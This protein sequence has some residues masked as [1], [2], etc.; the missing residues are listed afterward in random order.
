[1]A[2]IQKTV[3]VK[4][5]RQFTHQQKKIVPSNNETIKSTSDPSSAFL[6]D[7][8]N[9]LEMREL[10]F[11]G[12]TNRMVHCFLLLFDVC[13]GENLVLRAFASFFNLYMMYIWHVSH[14]MVP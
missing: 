14:I 11:D 4:R 6:I 1:M 8:I 7:Y 10:H 3:T 12:A 2:S 9:K 5:I 13:P